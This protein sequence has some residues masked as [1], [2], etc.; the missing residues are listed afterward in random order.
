M[1]VKLKDESPHGAVS[2]CRSPAGPAQLHAMDE[3]MAASKMEWLY[4]HDS[5]DKQV[6]D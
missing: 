5:S 3:S 4:E 1:T 6:V 2:S